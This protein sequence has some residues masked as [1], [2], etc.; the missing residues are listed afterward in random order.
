RANN[1]NRIVYS[2]GQSP[3]I[4]IATIGKSYLDVRQAL[5]D[6]GIG[7]EEANRL[8]IRLFKIACPWPLD[9]EHVAGFAQG[10][11]TIVVV[12]EKRS[13]IETQLREALY[14]RPDRPLIV[15]KKD[16][17]GDGLFQAAGALDPNDIAIALGERIVRTIGP[18]EDISARVSRLKQF[19]AMLADT[20]DVA[21]RMPYF[22]S[23][24]PHNSSTRVP[25]GSIAGAGIGCHFMT[26]WMGRSTVGFTAMGG[27]GA[28]WVGQ[29]PFTS[30]GHMFQNLGDGTY[31]HSGSLALRF[32]LAAGVNVTYKILYNDAVAM[33]GGQPHEG[34]LTV[35]M[36]AAQVRAEGV[37]RIAIVT[38]EP[39]KYAGKVSFP[40]GATIHHRRE[41]DAVQRELRDIPGV[42]V[43][44]Y[45]QTCA[46]EKRRRRKRGTFPDPDRRVFIND[47]VCEGCG[48]CGVVSNCVSVQPVET[49]FGRKRRIDQSSCNEDFSCGGGF[50]PSFVTVHGAKLRKAQ[51]LSGAADPLEGVP[52]PATFPLGG[53]GWSAIIDGIGGTG[54][55]TIG[56]VLGMAAHLE[57][58]GCGMIDMAG[59]AQKGGAVFSHL[60]VAATPQDINAIRVSA[61]KADLIL[62][63]D[64]VVSGS[65]KVLSAVREGET[66]FVVN[67]AEV[68]PGD[69]ARSAD[70]S[71]P[72]ERLKK[73]IRQA[74]GDS[75]AHF[76]DA[77]RAATV[78]FGNS[79]G[80]NMFML[81]IACQKGALPVSPEAVEKAIE[82]NGQAVKMN[83]DAFR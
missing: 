6:I 80:A 64:L 48:D 26:L 21:V 24:C 22:C 57:G 69:F 50:C 20:K 76:F 44:I 42:T 77:T 74:A 82:L 3:K 27:E 1:L 68:M 8:G 53:D 54:V 18:S 33:T 78:L 30:R 81:G 47:L 13:L 23:G 52:A 58:K 45:D 40:T 43:L 2:G 55:V 70:F 51:G 41:L 35:D 31:N 32:A 61:G 19:Q 49:E 25:E 62:G 10:L 71:L 59:L 72:T 16:E 17:R 11:E 14:D 12:E 5:D 28:Q 83:I 66:A 65:R 9:Q 46:A 7:E 56:A 38:D 15:G 29:A 37:E 75:H 67:T 63:C 4:G 73:A 36:I 34:G 79:L 39:E 60:R